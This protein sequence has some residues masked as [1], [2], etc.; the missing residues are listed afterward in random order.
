MYSRLLRSI[1]IQLS[2]F[3]TGRKLRKSHLRRFSPRLMLKK[4]DARQ[5]QKVERK[6]REQGN[7]LATKRALIWATSKE[8]KKGLRKALAKRKKRLSK[9]RRRYL[10]SHQQNLLKQ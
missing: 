6:A 9:I 3:W 2:L 4:L 7:W 8:K 5:R 10:S 1:W